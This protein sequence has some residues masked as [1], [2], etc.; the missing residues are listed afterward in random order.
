MAKFFFM[1]IL[2]LHDSAFW[3]ITLRSVGTV[4]YVTWSADGWRPAKYSPQDFYLLSILTFLCDVLLICRD[5]FPTF[6]E[7]SSP[8]LTSVLIPVSSP[9]F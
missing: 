8:L 4:T 1:M 2:R 3:W 7:V 9:M 6:S 5:S